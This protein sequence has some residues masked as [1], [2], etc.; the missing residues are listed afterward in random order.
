MKTPPQADRPICYGDEAE[1][2]ASDAVCRYCPFRVQCAAAADAVTHPPPPQFAPPIVPAPAPVQ[3][4]TPPP[5][6]PARVA[7]PPQQGAPVPPPRSYTTQPATT[8]AYSAYTQTPAYVQTPA[9]T[10]QAAQQP[11]V[12]HPASALIRPAKFNHNKPLLQQYAS[13]VLYDVAEVVTM[14]A[15]DLI[16]SCRTEYER[17]LME[18]DE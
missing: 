11:V 18:D 10:A 5:P 4:Y 15:T 2:N 17:E 13:Y 14:R 12:Q 7:P 1:Y 3:T 16:R 8:P 9:R 6:P